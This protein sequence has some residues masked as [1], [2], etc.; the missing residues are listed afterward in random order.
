MLSCERISHGVE[1]LFDFNWE[2]GGVW[3]WELI[4]RA[5]DLLQ[6]TDRFRFIGIDNFDRYYAYALKYVCESRNIEAPS[7]DRWGAAWTAVRKEVDDSIQAFRSSGRAVLMTAH[8]KEATVK[9]VSGGEYQ[10]IRPSI[11]GQALECASSLCDNMIYLEYLK[12]KSGKDIRV[13]I[14]EGDELIEA[15]NGLNLPK[16]LPFPRGEGYKTL[17]DAIEGKENGL[18]LNN[19]MIGPRNTEAVQNFMRKDRV[20][21]NKVPPRKLPIRK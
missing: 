16:Y 7:E 2:N 15:K 11:T 8:S 21:G 5:I 12:T 17:V 13:M 4:L 1:G 19:I 9:A 18:E 20:Q 14:T 3:C 10:R 6:T